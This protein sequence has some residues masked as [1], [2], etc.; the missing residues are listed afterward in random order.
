MRRLRHT[1]IVTT[2]GFSLIEV[3]VATSVFVIGVV[4]LAPLFL[5]ASRATSGAR[6]TSYAAVL[7]RDKME[8]LQSNPSPGGTL[9]AN[10]DGYCDF[11]DAN[12]RS[13]GGGTT[14]LP[15][16]AFV[17]RWSIEPI[18]TSPNTVVMQ[19]LVMPVL[20]GTTERPP[21]ATRAPNEARILN[22][23]TRRGL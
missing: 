4:G 14:P 6:T 1:F 17:R 22:A 21:G 19:V 2:S 13:L 23:K 7:A 12:G 18:P 8:D 20:H 16:T 11:L 10:T 9:S 3:L 5:F 15:N